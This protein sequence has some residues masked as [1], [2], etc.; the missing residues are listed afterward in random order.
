VGR[1]VLNV[2]DTVTQTGGPDG[3]K[4]G[5]TRK[6][7]NT[8]ILSLFPGCLG[9]SCCAPPYTS[10]YNGLKPLELQAS[11]SL[12]AHACNPSYLGG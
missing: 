1:P 12:V 11:W 9:M 6:P 10:C 5:K 2:G 8:G 7:A 4:R 3:I